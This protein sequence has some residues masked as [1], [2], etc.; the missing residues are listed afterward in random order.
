M[1]EADY[2]GDRI[3]VMGDGKLLTCGSSLFLKSK[4]G[5]GYGLTLVKENSAVSTEKVTQ[6]I[7]SY[8][9]GATLEGD[10]SKELKYVLPTNQLPQ[11]ENLFKELESRGKLEFG[12]ESYGV[13]L[14]TLEDVFL[15]IGQQLGKHKEEEEV[16]GEST[17]NKKNELRLQEIRVKGDFAIFMMHFKALVRKRFIYFKRD[18][19]S[20]ICEIILPI[21]IIFLGMSV[22]KI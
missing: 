9:P 6:L 7:E 21:I 18:K 1:D 13:S 4:F 10:I 2:L 16:L 15:R 20:L 11:F 17:K 8:I 12:I 22:T 19:K 3:G 14:T 5:F